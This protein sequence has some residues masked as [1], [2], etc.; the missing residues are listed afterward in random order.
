M[1]LHKSKMAEVGGT[2]SVHHLESYMH[3]DLTD[4]WN[5]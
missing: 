3:E 4:A 5:V 1:P 2:D